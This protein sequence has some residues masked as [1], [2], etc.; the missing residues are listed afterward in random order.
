MK[1]GFAKRY[2]SLH[3]LPTLLVVCLF[4]VSTLL[5]SAYGLRSYQA[6]QDA[7]D[8][9]Y[10]A[11][12]AV[13]YVATKLRQSSDA[14]RIEIPQPNTLVIVQEISNELYETKIFLENGKL[15]ESFGKQGLDHRVEAATIL[16]VS[17]FSVSFLS[18]DLVYFSIRDASGS[19]SDMT[20]LIP[21]NLSLEEAE[22][23]EQAEQERQQRFEEALNPAASP[24]ADATPTEGAVSE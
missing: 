23:A 20:M 10:N 4:A 14:Y 6:I 22:K 3:T 17:A 11:R 15:M 19:V 16:P 24:S 2:L 7:S 18:D 21:R 13:S 8:R 1:E 5:V 12:T 9:N